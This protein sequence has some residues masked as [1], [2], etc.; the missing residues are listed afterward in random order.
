MAVN[1]KG[2]SDQ[3]TKDN[4]RHGLDV[5]PIL[6]ANGGIYFTTHGVK[7]I[8]RMSDVQSIGNPTAEF[9]NEREHF[10]SGKKLLKLNDGTNWTIPITFEGD[11]TTDIAS[12]L[13]QDLHVNPV[14]KWGQD[15]SRTCDLVLY[16]VQDNEDVN[17]CD[18][19]FD[20][21]VKLKELPGSENAEVNF[22]LEVYGQE[23]SQVVRIYGGHSIGYE[24]FQTTGTHTDPAAPNGILTTFDLGDSLNAYAVAAP[25]DVLQ[26]NPDGT[27]DLQR[28]FFKV[29][30]NGVDV[31]DTEA[32][33][34]STTKTITFV[35]AP[36][37]GDKLEVWYLVD[38]AGSGPA[39]QPPHLHPG[40]SQLDDWKVWQTT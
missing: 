27:T 12:M 40:S 6:I 23:D 24:I 3:A 8:A 28:Y 2:G 34:N 32:S 16:S 14:L 15:K 1:L 4:V 26:A 36:A 9:I 33:F 18:A 11:H 5:I 39:G 21:G 38:Q 22:E 25:P 10:E 30:L 37:S 19:Y 31:S 7:G 35:T 17:I 20:L 13:A 29:R